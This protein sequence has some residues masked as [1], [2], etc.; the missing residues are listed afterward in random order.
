MEI[1]KENF[2]KLPEVPGVYTFWQNKKPIYIGK[3]VNLKSRLN[4]YLAV[5]LGVKT[6]QMVS[7]SNDLTFIEVQ[8]DLESLLL[9][10]ALIKKY[11]PKYN[12]V[13]KDDKHALYIVITN[14]E[15]PRVL[16]SRKNDKKGFVF[17]PFPN[18]TNVKTILKLIRKI[19]P[20]SDHKIGKKPCLY[21]HIGLCSP[22]PSEIIGNQNPIIKQKQT[23]QYKK[24][25]RNIKL[26]LSRKFNIVRKV[27]EKE[28]KLLSK[29]QKYE[30]AKIIRD[31][32][33]ALDYITQKRID[34]KS[35]L[36][37]PNLTEDL[38][39][40]ELKNLRKLLITYYILPIS[41]HRIECFD[42]AHLSGSSAT[43]SMVVA[44]DGQ[45][46]H[47]Y[48]RHFKIRQSKGNSDYDSMR[49]IAQRRI[50]H[51]TNLGKPN[52][53]IVDGGLGQVKIFND[54]FK[55]SKI[56]V[57]GIAKN[58]DRLVFPDGTKVRL[59][60]PTLQFVSRV[61]DEAHRFARRYHHKLISKSL[62]DI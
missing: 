38:R 6:Q 11:K 15:F 19:F 43:A 45:M 23:K 48:Y 57:I 20:F 58:P 56:P 50:N 54:I 29:Q 35:F 26:V 14:E 25:I 55:I 42:I 41:L 62:L 47:E 30:E 51:L 7:S 16:T 36:T 49:E 32:I 2:L 8:S 28:M 53:I 61:R 17:G 9:E 18:S 39:N 12:I 1:S 13:L 24:N 3:S 60:G 5:N 34:E 4:S 37:N 59:Q 21:S 44:I 33:Q 10:S 22:C 52:L 40:E 46:E 31:K 27:L